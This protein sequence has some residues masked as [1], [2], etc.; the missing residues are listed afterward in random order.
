ML[1]LLLLGRYAGHSLRYEALA[2]LGG[3]LLIGLGSAA[4]HGTLLWHYQLLDELPMLYASCIFIRSLVHSPAKKHHGMLLTAVLVVY[5]VV[6]TVIY[7][8]SRD[9]A[10]FVTAYGVQVA[11][12]ASG[13]FYH[14][15]RAPT[16][17]QRTQLFR[18]MLISLG[19][20]F[21]GLVLWNVDNAYCPKIRS[22]RASLP[23]ALQPLLQ[24]HAAWHVFSAYG[25]YVSVVLMAYARGAAD[26]LEP[27]LVAHTPLLYCK[28]T[29]NP[30]D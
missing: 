13:S 15:I 25:T 27:V 5:A 30:K 12:I 14:C 16:A 10:F 24:F 26:G 3:L 2:S 9:F 1:L 4:F 29:R 8:R 18:L 7:V 28:A 6:V 23:V 22:L 19:F 21:N 20:Y 11:V 17:E